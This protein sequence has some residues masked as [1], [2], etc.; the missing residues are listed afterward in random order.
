MTMRVNCYKIQLA[1][2][3]ILLITTI[4]FNQN[5]CFKKDEVTVGWGEESSSV[6]CTI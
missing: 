4:T 1:V 5:C 3:F 6:I 2:L